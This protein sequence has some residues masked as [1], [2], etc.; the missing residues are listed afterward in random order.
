MSRRAIRRYAE[1]SVRPWWLITLFAIVTGGLPGCSG[2]A[3]Q[4]EI[5]KPEAAAEPQVPTSNVTAG[6]EA[7]ADPS[8]PRSRSDDSAG[9]QPPRGEAQSVG[10][11]PSSGGGAEAVPPSSQPGSAADALA[12]AQRLYQSA[13]RNRTAGKPGAAFQEATKAWQTANGFPEDQGCRALAA[14]VFSELDAYAREA[15]RSATSG[16]GTVDPGKTLIE[17]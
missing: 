17:R 3:S 6:A 7:P 14:T 10:V 11:Q 2:C 16:T 9:Q 12:E 15:N 13:Q 5:S 1:C 8:P 4:A